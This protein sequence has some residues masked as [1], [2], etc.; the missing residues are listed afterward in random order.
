[1]TATP[2][3]AATTVRQLLESFLAGDLETFTSYTYDDIEW[4]PPSTTQ[5][6]CSNTKAGNNS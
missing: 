6:S 2:S 4:T 3:D 1:M 5:S